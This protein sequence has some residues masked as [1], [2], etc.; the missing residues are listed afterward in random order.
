M[1]DAQQLLLIVTVLVALGFDF[2]NGF[3]DTANAVATTVSTR[4][5]GPRTAV[6]MSSLLNLVGAVVAIELL[7]TRVSNTVGGL[8]SPAGGVELRFIIAALAAAIVWNLVTWR[9]GLPSSSSHALIGALVGMGL[10]AY[11]SSAV[12]WATVVPVLLTLVT[13]PLIGLVLAFLLSSLLLNV[14][15]KA[16]PSRA[17]RRFRVAQ[18]FSSG[19]VSFSHGANDAQKTMAIITLALVATGHL[20]QAGGKL[21]EPPLWVVFAS[22][23]AIGFGTY[24]GGW[25]IIRTLG[26]R[27]IRLEPLDGFVAQTTAALVIQGATQLALPVSTTHVVSGSVMGAGASRRFAAVRWS[28]ARSILVAWGLTI[29]A[30]ALLAALGSLLARAV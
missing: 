14:F 6:G 30:T 21:P 17:N 26:T 7:H 13:S 25:R 18:I 5:L 8:V 3:H 12:K 29:P 27:I 23:A 1:P 20:A 15:R 4:A 28:V 24:A 2:T 16:L 11:G 19:F 9:L 22:A 10:V